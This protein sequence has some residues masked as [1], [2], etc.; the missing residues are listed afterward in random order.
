MRLFSDA[1]SAIADPWLRRAYVL[2]EN[3]RGTTSP[4]P[5]VGC[6]VVRDGLVVGEGWHERAGGPH[7][8]VNAIAQASEHARGGTAYVTLEPCNHHGRTAPCAPA[9]VA[10]GVAAVVIGMRDPNPAVE[11]GGAEALRAAGI[12]VRFAEDAT[13]FKEQNEGWIKHATTGVPWVRAKVA[14][15]LDGH[16]SLKAG[17]RAAL[18]GPESRAITMRLRASADA[19]LVGAGTAAVDDP[20]LAVCDEAAVPAERQPLRVVLARTTVPPADAR[21]FADGLAPSLVLISSAV[22][23]DALRELRDADVRIE[24]YDARGGL[25][26]ALAALGRLGVVNVLAEPGPRLLE[27]LWRAHLIDE[28]VLYHTGGMA[29]AAAPP[30]FAAATHGFGGDVVPRMQAIEAGVAGMDAVTVWRACP[31]RVCDMERE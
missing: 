15:S 23:E 2:A 21:L 17:E 18:S 28:L 12:D 20:S 30:L 14:L 27:A 9:L 1:A 8:E 31:G 25:E 22:E 3:G 11:G 29:G 5:L 6:V 13:P 7:A 26:A 24:R 16:S 10:A 19:V 4:N